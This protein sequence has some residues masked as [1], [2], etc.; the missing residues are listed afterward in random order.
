MGKLRIYTKWAAMGLVGALAV[1]GVYTLT[2]SAINTQ[3]IKCTGVLSKTCTLDIGKSIGDEY[4]YRSVRDVLLNLSAEDTVNVYIHGTGGDY[5]GIHYLLYQLYHTKAKVVGIVDGE[6]ASAHAAFALGIKDLQF[7]AD[8]VVLFHLASG[9]NMVN[10]ICKVNLRPEELDRGISAVNKCIE[11]HTIEVDIY[12][13]YVVSILK[14]ILTKQEIEYM[15]QGHDIIMTLME[16]KH[17]L[18]VE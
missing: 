12:N 7:T 10:Q 2:P 17:R 18:G 13:N 6:I 14:R 3:Y 5:S 8:G 4:Q 9:T 16:F 1:V 11:N 15:Y